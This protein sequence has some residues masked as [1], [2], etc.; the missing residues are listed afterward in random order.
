MLRQKAVLHGGPE[1]A[2]AR[3]GGGVAETVENLESVV[4]V[5]VVVV[6]DDRVADVRLVGV[7]GVRR[8]TPAV[9]VPRIERVRREAPAA[10]NATVAVPLGG[11]RREGARRETLAERRFLPP[12]LVQRLG[13][14]SLVGDENRSRR[15]RRRPRT[16]RETL[17]EPDPEVSGRLARKVAR[18][19]VA[20]GRGGGLVA[21]V[22]RRCAPPTRFQSGERAARRRLG[23]GGEV[24]DGVERAGFDARRERRVQGLAPVSGDRGRASRAAKT[25]TPG[26]PPERRRAVSRASGPRARVVRVRRI[27]DGRNFRTP[28]PPRPRRERAGQRAKRL[29]QITLRPRLGGELGGFTDRLRDEI[30]RRLGEGDAKRHARARRVRVPAA[31]RRRQRPRLFGVAEFGGFGGD[32]QGARVVRHLR[33]RRQTVAGVRRRRGRARSEYRALQSRPTGLG[34]RAHARPH[35][36]HVRARR[37]ER[38]GDASRA[39]RLRDQQRFPGG[40][41]RVPLAEEQR[42]GG[43]DGVAGRRG[44]C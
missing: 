34:E 28:A 12:R 18:Q 32:E 44:S 26:N 43:A 16:R 9:G 6:D 11:G 41:K 15:F 33:R 5:L 7:R 17:Q 24:G 10:A 37:R 25:Q 14:L 42:D 30:E 3:D 2:P 1:P 31:G 4:V 39:E 20:D 22:A 13:A 23:L 29:D 36:L 27:R 35:L 21:R 38:S 19:N 40:A 8:E